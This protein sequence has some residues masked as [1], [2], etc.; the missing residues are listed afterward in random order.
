MNGHLTRCG[1]NRTG[2]SATL[3]GRNDSPRPG[4][5]KSPESEAP[6]PH[7]LNEWTLPL[8]A[9]HDACRTGGVRPASS[10]SV[11]KLGG[12]ISPKLP[13]LNLTRPSSKT[14][15]RYSE[16]AQLL[17]VFPSLVGPQT[18]QLSRVRTVSEH[19]IE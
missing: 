12:R 2:S 17:E 19:P 5:T 4:R 11:A 10:K 15:D 9:C 8:P 14:V 7:T 1:L 18:A 16:T 13:R 3:G 6:A